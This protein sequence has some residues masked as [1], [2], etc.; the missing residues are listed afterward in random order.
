MSID[1]CRFSKAQRLTNLAITSDLNFNKVYGFYGHFH[2]STF[3]LMQK[4]LGPKELKTKD[5]LN[6]YETLWHE[7]VFTPAWQELHDKVSWGRG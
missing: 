1:F 2:E 4:N 6:D 7:K 3:F 5:E